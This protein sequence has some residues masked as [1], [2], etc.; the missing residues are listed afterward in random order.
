MLVLKGNN[1]RF[2]WE[3]SATML[4]YRLNGT[5]EESASDRNGRPH[6]APRWWCEQRPIASQNLR[7]SRRAPKRLCVA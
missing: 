3:P 1:P 2:S 6:C 5:T 7:S 4:T